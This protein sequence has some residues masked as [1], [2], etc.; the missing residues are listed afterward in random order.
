MVNDAAGQ[1]GAGAGAV[2]KWG[3]G[4]ATSPDERQERAWLTMH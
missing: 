4:M 2:W 3:G 1:D